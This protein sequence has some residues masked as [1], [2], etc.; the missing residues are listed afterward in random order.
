MRDGTGSIEYESRGG[1]LP[2]RQGDLEHKVQDNPHVIGRTSH[3]LYADHRQILLGDSA[4]SVP[5]E[6]PLDFLDDA[7]R[8]RLAISADSPDALGIL[9]NAYDYVPVDVEV[10]DEP[11]L[12]GVEGW[13]HVVDASMEVPTGRIA[14][15]GVTDFSPEKSPYRNLND[16]MAYVSP[17]ITVPPGIYRA[18]V[19]AGGLPER[20]TS[21]N[22]PGEYYRVVLWPEPYADPKV[23]KQGPLRG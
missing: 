9:T 3:R 13:D 4:T 6:F 11:P 5:A 23:L 8:L 21:Q 1:R 15:D 12:E 16:P 10:R 14:I 18:R 19:Y 7:R 20:A 22:E 17:H 2:I